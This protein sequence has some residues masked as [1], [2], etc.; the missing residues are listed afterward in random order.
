[1]YKYIAYGILIQT[2]AVIANCP[3]D[4]KC[5]ISAEQMKVNIKCNF[6]FKTVLNFHYRNSNQTIQDQLHS[7]VQFGIYTFQ[8]SIIRAELEC[9]RRFIWFQYTNCELYSRI[10]FE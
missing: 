2:V 6:N 7:S 1:M 5:Q 9:Y 4:C 10:S 3:D 8:D